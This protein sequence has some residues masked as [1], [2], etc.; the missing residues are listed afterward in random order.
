MKKQTQGEYHKANVVQNQDLN[1]GPAWLKTPSFT[2]VILVK[3]LKNSLALLGPSTSWPLTFW[4]VHKTWSRLPPNS[5]ALFLYLY[6]GTLELHLSYLTDLWIIKWPKGNSVLLT[7]GSLPD[8]TQQRILHKTALLCSQI[9]HIFKAEML[10]QSFTL[11]L[12]DT[13]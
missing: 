8:N 12:P 2:D 6:S 11:Q 13:G 5:E 9:A 1:F 4:P 7:T 10:I 3:P